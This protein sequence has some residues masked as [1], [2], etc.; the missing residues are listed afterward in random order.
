M[1]NKKRKLETENKKM[2][3]SCFE[4]CEPYLLLIG[5]SNNHTMCHVCSRRFESSHIHMNKFPNSF[6]CKIGCRKPLNCPL[7]NESINGIS[8]IFVQ[9][10]KSECYTC[11]YL[12]FLSDKKCEGKFSAKDLQKHLIKHHNK[13]VICPNCDT[14]LHPSENQS[15]EDILLFHILRKC[16]SIPCNGCDRK[17]N[18][19]NLHMH[20]ITGNDSICE[21]SQ[22]IFKR[23]GYNLSEY[24]FLFDNVETLKHISFTMLKWTVE[25]IYNRIDFCEKPLQNDILIPFIFNCFNEYHKTLPRHNSEEYM[26]IMY[27]LENKTKEEYEEYILNQLATYSHNLNLRLD[28][29]SK[30]SFSYRLILMSLSNYEI[31]INLW[32]KK[33]ENVDVEKV[34]TLINFYI[35]IDKEENT[36][37]ITFRIPFQ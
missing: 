24:F 37:T 26:N 13:S 27:I 28:Q 32:N 11:P 2:C 9:E 3:C 5:C 21:S 25:Y 6:P 18:M 4:E 8:N 7:C 23:F 33:P 22:S 34:N 20:S 14:W 30:L 10:G 29:T 1:S 17:C 31:A 36:R 12:E 19:I 16:Q 35:K 15:V